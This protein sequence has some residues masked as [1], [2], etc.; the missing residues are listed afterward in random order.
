MKLGMIG[1]SAGNGHPWSFSAIINGYDR[2]RFSRCGWPVIFEYLER[3]EPSEF[4]VEGVRVS[5]VWTQDPAVSRAIAEATF[6][7]SICASPA[8]MLEEVDAVVVARDDWRSHY[9]IAIEFL[10]AGK[11]V[12]V[13]KPL[14]LD[15]KELRELL[16]YLENAQLMSCAALRY[17]AELDEYR[18]LCRDAQPHVVSASVVLDWPRYGVHLLDG[19]F[20]GIE[21][22]VE[23]V[24]A[25]GDDPRVAILNCASGRKISLNCVG[26]SERTF[27][28][29]FFFPDRRVVCEVIDNFTA[30]KRTLTVFRNQMLERRP[31]IDPRL[32]LGIMKVL[33][34]G[35]RSAALNRVVYL[36]EIDV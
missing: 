11:H 19:I 29:S 21:F 12:F 32:T 8:T 26:R 1:A 5:S 28:F 25:A 20:S 24:F 36:D 7:D 18:V 14:S 15:T 9:P 23:S 17:A 33:I 35:E 4:G 16:P 22:D 34:A 13:D 10:R 3:R 30:F 2:E 31:A 6:I 27:R